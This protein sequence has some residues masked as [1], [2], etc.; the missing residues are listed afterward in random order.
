MSPDLHVLIVTERPQERADNHALSDLATDDIRVAVTDPDQCRNQLANETVHALITDFDSYDAV[1]AVASG[2]PIIVYDD[3]PSPDAIAAAYDAGVATVIQRTPESVHILRETLR[4]MRTPKSSASR[5]ETGDNAY[6]AAIV[7]SAADCIITIDADSIIQFANSAV[8]TLF[9]YEPAELIGEPLTILMSDDL[10]AQ[11]RAAVARYLETNER[12]FDW[13]Y[14]ELP[15]V[16]KDGSDVPFGV[17]FAEFTQGGTQYFTG[18]IRDIADRKQAEQLRR[19][20]KRQFDAVF[21][22][23][24]TFFALLG[25]DGTVYNVN[26]PAL[27]IAN[28][29]VE[30]VVG[31]QFWECPWWSHS[32]ALQAQLKAELE[33]VAD[34]EYSKFEVTY[35]RSDG[36]TVTVDF[37]AR[38]VFVGETVTGIVAEGLD[39]S[40]EKRL[41]DELR[42]QRNLNQ[43]V[44]DTAPVGIIILDEAGTIEH[45]NDRAVEIAGVSRERLQNSPPDFS[46]TD[47]DGDPLAVEELPF[48]KVLESG[49]TVYDFE[50]GVTRPDGSWVWLSINGSRARVED[51][52]AIRG[53]FTLEDITETKRRETRFEALNEK[54]QQLPEAKTAS[55][56]CSIVV[57]AATDVLELP[58]TYILQYDEAE[59]DLAPA[60]QTNG[61]AALVDSPLLGEVGDS[62]VWEVFIRDEAT[63][64][65]EFAAPTEENARV[66]SV[67]IFPLGEFGVFVTCSPEKAA[68]R[69]TDLL[70]AGMLCS[71][72]RSSLNRAAREADLRNQRDRL[73]QKNKRL[74][75]VNRINRAIRDI[76]K[77]LIQADTQE[78]IEDLVCERLADIDPFAF[79]W[80]GDANP[81]TGLITP[82]SSA[83]AGDGY[84]DHITV[85]TDGTETSRGPAGL[86]VETREPQVQNNILTDATFEPWREEALSRGF[87]ASAAVPILY[88]DTV[89]GV[90]NLYSTKPLVFEEM[91]LSVL[92]ELGQSIGYAM[93]ALE[94]K[95]ALV[96]ESSVELEFVISALKTPILGFID[97]SEGEFTLKNAVRRLDGKMHLFFN[98]RGIAPDV[99]RAHAAAAADV[100]QF[101]LI[102]ETDDECLCECT[103]EDSTFISTLIE[104]GASLNQMRV[105][106][107]TARLKVRIPQSTD[108]RRFVA[109]LDSTFGHVTLQARREFDTPVMTQ[110]EFENEVRNRLT[111]RQ[112]EVIKT[113]YF[114]GFFEWPRR[115]NGQEVAEI[116]G[117]TQP[118]VNRHIRAG[119]R[120]LFNLLFD[121]DERQTRE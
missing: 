80:I 82:V 11:H 120:T 65:S 83:G 75:R 32:P 86:A 67:G 78:E 33:R 12:R 42:T 50:L 90:L 61:A 64:L 14:A 89:Y 68:F 56:V 108:V 60:A 98:V 22:D 46:F 70:L 55:E 19:K 8:Q 4:Q 57:E 10:A 118:T 66:Q 39:I 109:Y 24:F 102:G 51:G 20:R 2:H 97:G 77:V 52:D 79:V 37:Q 91:E 27:D 45:I 26:Q 49:A 110:Q 62:P 6:L 111:K 115:S 121:R 72:A 31:K 16:H 113:A 28:V 34:G 43:Q 73:E 71:N 53:I 36:T 96:S 85:T 9:G 74:N 3:P 18:V 107:G 99:I 88:R 101:T 58:Y 105:E 38:P 84:L 29:S 41:Q 59:G 103:I 87:R 44:I 104:R 15:G 116:L 119:E 81:T 48:T 114:S 106:D 93:N 100:S 47:G 1:C 63:V 21:N 76:T 23:P 95:R 25:P 7:E 69:E 54:A 5:L 13:S 30:D 94:R 17:S 112:E 35:E 92:G 117:V 40:E